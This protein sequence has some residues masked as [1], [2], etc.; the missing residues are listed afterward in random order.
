MSQKGLTEV[1]TNRL[2]IVF[3][4]CSCVRPSPSL[5]NV[6][7]RKLCGGAVRSGGCSTTMRREYAN[8]YSSIPERRSNPSSHSRVGDW[9]VWFRVTDQKAW[10]AAQR[11]RLRDVMFDVGYRA[12][13][14][15]WGE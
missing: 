9:L 3:S 11:M 6:R 1:A 13:P 4:E 8:V 7:E 15:V 12:K 10:V 14:G 2:V 5:E